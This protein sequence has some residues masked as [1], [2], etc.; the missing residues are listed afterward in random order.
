MTSWQGYDMLFDVYEWLEPVALDAA[1]L[2]DDVG[3]WL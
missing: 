2:S 1:E 3:C